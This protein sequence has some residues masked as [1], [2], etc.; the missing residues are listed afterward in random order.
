MLTSMA[1]DLWDIHDDVQTFLAA[2]ATGWTDEEACCKMK[3]KF[4]DHWGKHATAV[5]PALLAAYNRVMDEVDEQPEDGT[6]DAPTKKHA[7]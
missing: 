6:K 7:S 1:L 2:I 5:L 3:G 4:L